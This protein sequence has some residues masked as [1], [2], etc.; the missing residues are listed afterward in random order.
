MSIKLEAKTVLTR[1]VVRAEHGWTFGQLLAVL[2]CSLHV[3]VTR[4]VV[5]KNK[6]FVGPTFMIYCLY[7]LIKT[8]II[9]F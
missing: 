8:V 9:V 5:L 3:I 6:M 7:I 1:K 2:N 4:V